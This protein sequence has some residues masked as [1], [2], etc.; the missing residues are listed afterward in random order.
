M[1]YINS[2]VIEKTASDILEKDAGLPEFER[3]IFKNTEAAAYFRQFYNCIR[4]SGENL[5]LEH[6][7]FGFLGSLIT[8]DSVRN[9]GGNAM[10][11]DD[12]LMKHAA[13]LLDENLGQKFTLGELA[14]TLDLSR[15][16]FIRTFKRYSGVPPHIYRTQKRIA[17][18]KKL[19]L[20][21]YPF[22]DIALQTGFTDQ[23][24]FTNQFKKYTGATPSQYL[25]VN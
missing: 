22:A 5:E 19:I 12:Q 10:R 3:V 13:E 21:G 17:A 9:P 16:H 23:S 1:I 7:L 14:E 6:A 18:A 20:K 2:S 15:Y 4:A 25:A 24:H 11:C 8:S